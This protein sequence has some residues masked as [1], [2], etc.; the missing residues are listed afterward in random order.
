MSLCAITHNGKRQT[1]GKL[2]ENTAHTSVE[3]KEILD[4]G[5]WNILSKAFEDLLHSVKSLDTSKV[6]INVLP[7]NGYIDITMWEEK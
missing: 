4:N 7:L 6:R 5:R 2:M 1:K 3:L